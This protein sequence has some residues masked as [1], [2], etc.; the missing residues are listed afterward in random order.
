MVQIH[1]SCSST[2]KNDHSVRKRFQRVK[3]LR[4]EHP[5]L[6]AHGYG[7]VTSKAPQRPLYSKNPKNQ[8]YDRVSERFW[9]GSVPSVIATHKVSLIIPGNYQNIRNPRSKGATHMHDQGPHN[10]WY[11][12]SRSDSHNAHPP[13]MIAQHALSAPV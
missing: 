6:G 8:Q 7:R 3:T 2:H 4:G 5:Y 13:T 12:R 11:E 1:L 9:S 10:I